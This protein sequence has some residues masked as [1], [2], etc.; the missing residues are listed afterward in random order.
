MANPQGGDPAV[1]PRLVA[2]TAPGGAPVMLEE[3]VPEPPS[4]PSTSRG[5]SPPPGPPMHI[6][7][8]GGMVRSRVLEYEAKTGS[9]SSPPAPKADA[10][11][12]VVAGPPVP[13]PSV[14]VP[15]FNK[16]NN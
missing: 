8:P 10:V 4:P 13:C 5:G 6:P 16:N 14:Q 12:T 3:P 7:K 9:V 1:R 11:G 2:P 15:D